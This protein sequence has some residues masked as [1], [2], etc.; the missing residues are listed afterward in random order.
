MLVPG[1]PKKGRAWHHPCPQVASSLAGQA[2]LLIWA[3]GHRISEDKGQDKQNKLSGS[4]G[5]RVGLSKWAERKGQYTHGAD[6]ASTDALFTPEL[7]HL[8]EYANAFEV[9]CP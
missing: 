8:N 6:I 5:S 7:A 1:D 3:R 9:L 2:R 4:G